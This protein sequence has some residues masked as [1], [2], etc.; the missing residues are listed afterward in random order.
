M[1]VPLIAQLYPEAKDLYKYDV[2]FKKAA[3]VIANI[4]RKR[5]LNKELEEWEVVIET[6]Y[7]DDDDGFNATFKLKTALAEQERKNRKEAT[8]NHVLKDI[9]VTY[10]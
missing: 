10:T 1:Q 4:K 2:H 9:S 7:M 5:A 6:K 8:I 3:T